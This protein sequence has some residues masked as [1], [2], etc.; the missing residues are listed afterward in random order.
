L[1]LSEYYSLHS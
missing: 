1:H